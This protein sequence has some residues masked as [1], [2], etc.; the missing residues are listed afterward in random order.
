MQ[1]LK[2]TIRPQSYFA[3]AIHGD[4]LF[5]QLCWAVVRKLGEERLQQLLN[6]Y[7]SQPFAVLSDAFPAGYLPRPHL[8]Q[9]MLGLGK[10]DPVERKAFKRKQWIPLAATAQ[11]VDQWLQQA[12]TDTEILELLD[13]QQHSDGLSQWHE[14]MH[15][16]INRMTG[17]TGE[18][19]FAPYSVQTLWFAAG[20]DWDI[21]VC[22]D[23]SQ[24][25]QDELIELIKLIGTT[26]YG[27]DASIGA[28]RFVVISVSSAELPHH[29]NADA[30]LTLA[31]V[32]PQGLPLKAKGCF[33]QPLTR[34]GR[35][36]DWA[37]L[38][39]PY[40]APIL[41]AKTAAVL[42]LEQLEQQQWFGQA[43]GGD[44]QISRT[45]SQ[46]VHQG[47]APVLRI[48]LQA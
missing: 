1:T 38:V 18:G 8:P 7:T 12:L 44:G 3:T 45:I 31:A 24:L 6:S 22:L 21:Y 5:G 28:G 23:D 33:Y 30:V 48:A 10:L 25:S 19:G 43:L 32:A 36:G 26:G 42:T 35:H 4:T 2:L 27:K 40:K 37:V 11:P 34:F 17:S 13:E 16:S 14:Q 47:Y 41:M 39:N 15:N 46:T 29:N 20:L 9:A